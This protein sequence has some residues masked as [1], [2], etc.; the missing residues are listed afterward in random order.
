MA[1]AKEREIQLQFLDE[2]QDHLQMLE[3]T[4]MSLSSRRVDGAEMNAALRAAHSMKGGGSLMGFPL[5]SD[6]SHQLE[7]SL[8]VLKIQKNSVDPDNELESL[9]L[10]AVDCLQSIVNCDRQQIPVS[11]TW[12]NESVRPIFYQLHDRLGDPQDENAES[13]LSTSTEEGKDILPILFETEVEECLQRIERILSQP[14]QPLLSEEILILAQE[15]GGLGAMLQISSFSQLCAS[16]AYTM[17]SAPDRAVDIAQVAVME[18]RRS[19]SLVLTQQLDLLPTSIHVDGIQT[20]MDPNLDPI[21][22]LANI[23]TSLSAAN[24]QNLDQQDTASP[25]LDWNESGHT[26][27]HAPDMT[28]T[29]TSVSHKNGEL[30]ES[31]E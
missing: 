6:L 20:Q 28:M 23:S 31:G 15:L 8:K 24:S 27:S 1:D 2:A 12:L 18:W 22:V 29:E 7:D 10:S 4:F 14:T 26:P 16:I 21:D 11:E 13:L 5:L 25:I 17:K 19:Q 30:H 3:S 9:L